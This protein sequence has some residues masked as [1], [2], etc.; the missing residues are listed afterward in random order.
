MVLP[1]ETIQDFTTEDFTDKDI[2]LMV[3]DRV[4]RSLYW[5][6]DRDEAVRSILEAVE[7]ILYYHLKWI[8]YSTEDYNRMVE[9]KDSGELI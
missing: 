5:D 9:W 6:L 7:I 4:L 3:L 1:E 2:D 8:F